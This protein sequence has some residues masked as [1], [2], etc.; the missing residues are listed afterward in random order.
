M[1][2]DEVPSP[3]SPL[4]AGQPQGAQPFLIRDPTCAGFLN[5]HRFLRGLLGST[6]ELNPQGLK[7]LQKQ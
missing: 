5:K 4:Q 3:S 2:I 6:G 7:C 1:G